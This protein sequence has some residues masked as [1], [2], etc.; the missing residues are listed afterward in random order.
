MSLA[1]FRNAVVFSTNHESDFNTTFFSIVFRINLSQNYNT[2]Y[3]ISI[4]SSWSTVR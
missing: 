3:L 2:F 4:F 1:N